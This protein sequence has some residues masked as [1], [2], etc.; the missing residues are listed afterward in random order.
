L[1]SR[2]SPAF[3][4]PSSDFRTGS[5]F[6]AT[7][8]AFGSFATFRVFGRRFDGEA[9]RRFG[10]PARVT[11]PISER[12]KMIVSD[13]QCIVFEMILVVFAPISIPG[14]PGAGDTG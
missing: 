13:S 7:W 12:P 4:Q 5:E 1:S 6:L 3:V 8:R 10:G 14:A 11:L 9:G 2:G